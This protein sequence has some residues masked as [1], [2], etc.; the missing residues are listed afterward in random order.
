MEE[1]ERPVV[2]AGEVALELLA[3]VLRVHGII[4]LVDDAV[5][6]IGDAGVADAHL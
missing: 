4:E 6:D 3:D 5:P 1:L 2:I